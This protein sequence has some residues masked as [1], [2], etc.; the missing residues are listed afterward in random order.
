M[1]RRYQYWIKEGRKLYGKDYPKYRK[2]IQAFIKLLKKI[3]V[4]KKELFN[5]EPN[6][7]RPRFEWIE[8]NKRE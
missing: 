4:M 5:L 3:D 7:I 1:K 8:K 6:Q 2:R